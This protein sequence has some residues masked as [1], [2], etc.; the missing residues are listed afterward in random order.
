MDEQAAESLNRYVQQVGYAP[1]P[2]RHIII[3]T[4]ISLGKVLFLFK[5]IGIGI[6]GH[7]F[8]K[9]PNLKFD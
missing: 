3:N 5:V 6:R 2:K 4:P 9:I 8:I 7:I 1:P